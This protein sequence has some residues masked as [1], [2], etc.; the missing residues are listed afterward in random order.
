MARDSPYLSGKDKLQTVI[1]LRSTHANGIPKAEAAQ[2]NAMLRLKRKG[3]DTDTEKEKVYSTPTQL[4]DTFYANLSKKWEFAAWH[5]WGQLPVHNKDNGDYIPIAGLFV[6]QFDY[7]A[8]LKKLIDFGWK[9][10]KIPTVKPGSGPL[11]SNGT[12]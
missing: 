12:F 8:E 2:L 6:K 4:A 1:G 10:G 9:S 5:P 11:R 7:P 3:K